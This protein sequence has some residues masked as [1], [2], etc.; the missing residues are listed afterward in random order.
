MY[1]LLSPEFPISGD[2]VVS[3]SPGAGRVPF[4]W[5]IYLLLLGGQRQESQN[6]TLAPTVA[7][8]TLIQINQYATLA[9]FS[10]L[11]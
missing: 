3:L 9:Y 8:V 5:E 4:I 2:E 10:S 11:P 1:T 6:V 7:Y